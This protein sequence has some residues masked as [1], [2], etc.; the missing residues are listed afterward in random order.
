[1]TKNC[2]GKLTF[3]SGKAGDYDIWTF[4]FGSGELSQ[5]TDGDY[6]NDKPKWSPDGRSIVFVS[7]RTGEQE[8]Y[9]VLAS[10]GE[11]VQLT[12]LNRWVDAPT[13]SPDGTQLAFIS[14]EAGNNDIWVMGADG[15]NPRQVTRHEGSDDHVEWTQDGQGL[16]WSTDREDGDADIW[17]INLAT[18]KKTKLTSEFGADITPVPSPDGKLIAFV[19]NRQ[20]NSDAD[21]PFE[22]RDKDIWLMA[23]DG[24]WPVRL[25]KNQGA[26][27]CPSWSPDGEYLVYAAGDDR[28]ACHLRVLDVSDVTAAFAARDQNRVEKA[29]RAIRS[30]AI[31]L[32]RDPLKEDIGARRYTTIVTFWWPE[33]WVKSCYPHE[34][35]GLE[36]YPHWVADPTTAMSV[37]N[38][39]PAHAE[40]V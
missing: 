18:Q 12:K 19:S 32:D 15:E 30:E 2:T 17:H 40:T 24:G 26:D 37:N 35:F 22:D 3:A 28:T 1:M 36:R 21:R 4:A 34:Y 13:F 9:K 39:S 20:L 25:T 8:I 31:S 38:L 14:N 23:A 5:I 27:Y 11:A 10:G 7:N 16:L 6:W 33:K 29:A